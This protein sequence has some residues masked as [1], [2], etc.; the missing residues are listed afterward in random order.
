MSNQSFKEKVAIPY[1]EA[2]LGYVQSF[3]LLDKATQDLSSISTVLSKSEDLELLLL[4]P[5]V[6]TSIKK[7]V[8]KELFQTQ[9]SDFVMNFL[10]VLVDRR[11]ISI[12][13]SIIKKYLELA[14]ILEST[15]VA[16]V[17]SAIDISELQQEDL[18]NKVKLMTKSNKVKLTII[19][20]SDLIGGFIIKIGSK[21]VDVSLAG[22]L[23]QISLYLNVS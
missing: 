16:E 7:N 19:K 14:C 21:V 6:R 8:L 18:I 15:V 5:L 9:V 13:D 22:K 2:L 10:F 23:K 20:D 11:R 17:Y 3:N 4:N 1:A 12:L